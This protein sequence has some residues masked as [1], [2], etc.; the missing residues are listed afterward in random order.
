MVYHHKWGSGELKKVSATHFV[1]A[2][3]DSGGGGKKW[4][5]KGKRRLEKSQVLADNLDLTVQSWVIQ[6]HQP[7]K[8]RGLITLHLIGKKLGETGAELRFP[9]SVFFSLTSPSEG[10]RFQYK[11]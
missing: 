2:S 1:F 6:G 8:V 5:V 7:I 10:M 4:L 11:E 3:V 9:E